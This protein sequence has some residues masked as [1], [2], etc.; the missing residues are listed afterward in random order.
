MRGF[1]TPS[2]RADGTAANSVG[3]DTA[4]RDVVLGDIFQDR[5]RAGH[6]NTAMTPGCLPA[7]AEW[8]FSVPAGHPRRRRSSADR[9]HG[10]S[11]YI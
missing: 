1:V 11:G 6:Q 8:Y 2:Y 5:R 9:S 10:E 4:M 3:R 7:P